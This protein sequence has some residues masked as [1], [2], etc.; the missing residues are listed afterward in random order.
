MRDQFKLNFTFAIIKMSTHYFIRNRLFQKCSLFLIYHLD[1]KTAYNLNESF[2]QYL[3]SLKKLV[4]KLNPN[5]SVFVSVM[6]TWSQNKEDKKIKSPI[7]QITNIPIYK[8][9]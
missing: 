7:T 4:L 6:R 5:R 1:F 9:F 3:F 2:K 8:K